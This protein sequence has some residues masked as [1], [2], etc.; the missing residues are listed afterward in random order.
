MQKLSRTQALVRAADQ[1]GPLVKWGRGQ[2]HYMH[3]VDGRGWYQS[4][5]HDYYVARAQR[6]R[7]I[8]E[9]AL[10]LLGYD[11]P[12]TEGYP[13]TPAEIVRE[14]MRRHP[15]AE[16]PTRQ[17]IADAAADYWAAV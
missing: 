10:C 7:S 2:W 15:L 12:D 4:Q 13:G 5:G 17:D 11:M 8:A 1:H 6:A 16:Q 14:Y 9:S 3:R